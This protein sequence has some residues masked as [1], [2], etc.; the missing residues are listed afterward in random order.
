VNSDFR[1]SLLYSAA[2]VFVIPSV[3]EAFGQTALEA[4]ACG[5]PV[6]GS[7][8]GGIPEIVQDNVTGWLVPAASPDA[9]REAILKLLHDSEK[10]AQMSANCRR[11]VLENYTLEAQANR[12]ENLYREAIGQHSKV[13]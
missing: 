2:D 12:Y 10:R 11:V 7:A 1:L 6:V 4:M 13:V 3:Q 5:T 9:L 8:V